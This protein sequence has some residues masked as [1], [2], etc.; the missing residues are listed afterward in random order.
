[1]IDYTKCDVVAEDKLWTQSVKSESNAVKKWKES[2][3]FLL[4][5][6]AKVCIT[7]LL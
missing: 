1:M 3:G 2:W 4:E 7:Y 5:Y 6:D